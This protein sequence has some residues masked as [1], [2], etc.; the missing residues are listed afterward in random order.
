[1]YSANGE[2]APL[3]TVYPYKEK[4]PEGVTK[5]VPGHWGIG[6][7]E[8]G[9]MTQ[10]VFYEYI[11]NVF[12]KWLIKNNVK[13][14]I[15]VYL[16]GHSSHLTIPLIEFGIAYQIEFICFVPHSTHIMQPLDIAFFHSLKETWLIQ[17]SK[18]KRENRVRKLTN[19][20]FSLVLVTAFNGQS[21]KYYEKW[22]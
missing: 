6:I 16:D 8:S 11:T 9:W 7:S 18:W 1:M 12:Y 2:K 3:I 15:I 19:I 20:T 10:E 4:L 17:L 13:F 5:N 22:L 14:P 21:S